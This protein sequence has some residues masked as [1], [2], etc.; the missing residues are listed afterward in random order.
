MELLRP[1][2]SFTPELIKKFGK[3]NVIVVQFAKGSQSIRKWYRDWEP[4]KEN[5]SK[6]EPYLY[7][8]LMI[9]IKKAIRKKKILT[10]TF[11]WMQG[12][13]DARKS[14]GAVYEKSL[15][16]LYKQLSADL[17]RKDI[18][19]VIGRLSDCGITKKGWPDWMQ[20]RN[21]QVKVAESNSRF[22]WIDTDDLN[23]GINRKGK[24]IKDGI[25]MTADGYVVMGERFAHKAIELIKNNKQ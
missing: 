3:K 12:E 5:E 24:K 2:E 23:T 18:N 13:R 17:G 21:I 22:G 7:D 15:L 11:I 1:K 16:G 25:H 19:F 10:V 20:I 8:S 4:A 9:K 14:R 6:A